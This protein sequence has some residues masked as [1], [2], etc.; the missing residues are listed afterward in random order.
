[1]P[2]IIRN[3]R[4]SALTLAALTLVLAA[5]NVC[6]GQEKTAAPAPE[7][8]AGNDARNDRLA[9]FLEARFGMFIHWGPYSELAGEWKGQRVE[10][11]RNAEWIMKFLKI[12]AA[13][14]R[15]M[16][17][18][19]HPVKFDAEAWVRL[20]QAT[21]MRY[22]VVTAKHHDGFAMYHSK[23]SPYNIV[24][25]TPFQRDPLKELSE[26]CARAGIRFC[27][28]YS[29]RED[30]DDPD[31][32]GNDWD[33]V[34]EKQDFEAY[35]E[36]KSKPQLRELLTHYGPVGLVWFDR[37][38]YTPEQA[39]DF[40][41]IVRGIQPA[42]LING[43]VGSYEH[44]L[45]GDYQNMNDNGMPAGGIEEDWETPQTLNETWGY[46]RFDTK[47]KKPEDI[48]RRLVEIVSKGGNYLLNIGPR[49]DGTIP[50]ASVAILEK[51]G[52]WM[53]SNSE[54]IYGAKASPFAG[55]PWGFCT[56]KENMLY[57]HVFK[58]P[59]DSTLELPGLRSQVKKVSLLTD[60]G[61]ILE[62]SR[63]GSS[64][65]IS[66]PSIPADAI[67]TV[68]AVELD[69]PPRVDPPVI[70]EQAGKPVVLDY[71]NA[72]TSGK[73]VKRFNRR[74][75]FHISK[76][77]GPADQASWRVRFL[78][79]GRY[80]VHLECAGSPG[81]PTGTFVLSAGDQKVQV[82]SPQASDWYKYVT[83]DAG[84]L[85]IAAA[86]EQELVLRPAR[87]MGQDVMCFKSLKFER[88]P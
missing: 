6:P 43:R 20:A 88:L 67:N 73:T 26:A 7:A 32:Y 21:G 57:L 74:G 53:Q 71:L 55:F 45:M 85:D 38:L 75:Q 25:W 22:L 51:V 81:R 47:W 24:D 11:G 60:S 87:E 40:V 30:W 3:H 12:P 86:G 80:R 56:V 17:R 83:L 8:A 66:L 52:E 29:H 77:T 18:Q 49:G 65:R 63:Q 37:G 48:V 2:N 34:P 44:E 59:A 23:V 64:V 35:L 62:S 41:Q 1:M 76:W 28:Y 13:E 5:G 19:F 14:Y 16:A 61:K 69:G 46:S 36:R 68:V 10:V 54:S 42:C 39:Q 27:V 78:Q 72:V 9:W 31:G 50:E 79:P 4:S 33:Y 58:R 82:E 84:V 15:E 70:T